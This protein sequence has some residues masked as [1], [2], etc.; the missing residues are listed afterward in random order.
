[1]RRT[2][3]SSKAINKVEIL[4]VYVYMYIHVVIFVGRKVPHGANRLEKV[5]NDSLRTCGHQTRSI[6]P[7]QLSESGN[8]IC[9][10]HYQVY[11]L[12]DQLHNDFHRVQ[13][14]DIGKT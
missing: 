1:M 4:L 13:G 8:F 9:P 2:N 3:N 7:I 11:F 12:E 10:G 6:I 5:K 14:V